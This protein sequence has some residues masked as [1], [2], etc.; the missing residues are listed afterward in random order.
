M[1]IIGL[2]KAGCNIAELFKQYPQY[3]VFKIDSDEKLK[4]KKNC[5]YIPKQSSVELYDANPVDLKRLLKN[6]DEDE[7]CFLIVCGSGKISGCALWTLRQL[8]EAGQDIRIIYIKPELSTLDNMAKLRNRAHFH[9]LQEYTRSGVFSKIFLIDN[10][11]MPEIV[12]KAPVINYYSKT[13]EF[14]V[15]TIH[16]YNIYRNTDPVFDTFRDEY[17][18]SRICAFSY[19]D[20]EEQKE[21]KTFSIENC[22]QIKYFYGINRITIEDDE[23]LLDRLTAIS[24]GEGNSPASIS[25]GIYSTDLETGYSFAVHSSSDIQE[26]E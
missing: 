19:I 2:G 18:S 15:S 14:I 21:T 1:N 23:T 13:N 24:L 26:Q 16:W 10:A 3:T 17:V 25:H 5:M 11:K 7:E 9:I 20:I 8:K 22:N 4:R 12:G 6:L